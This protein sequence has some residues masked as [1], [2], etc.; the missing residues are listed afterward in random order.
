MVLFLL[1]H[2]VGLG[3][4]IVASLI[5]GAWNLALVNSLVFLML[6]KLEIVLAGKRY[7]V[8]MPVY[9]D[10]RVGAVVVQEPQI[11]K[12]VHGPSVKMKPQ[13]KGVVPDIAVAA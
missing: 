10:G 4:V 3:G 12:P 8:P 2:Y 13:P 5:F 9:A 11:E 6:V 1:L 7:T